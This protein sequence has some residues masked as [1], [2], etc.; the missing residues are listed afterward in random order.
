[1]SDEILTV[2]E[3]AARLRVG[4]QRA[5]EIFNEQGFPSFRVGKFLRVK[6]CDFDQWVE[7]QKNGEPK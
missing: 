3:V 4:K 6:A 7:E 1:M 5:Y 2:A